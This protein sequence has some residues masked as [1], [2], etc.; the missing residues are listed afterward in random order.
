ML[1]A[2]ARDGFVPRGEK[3]RHRSSRL[4]FSRESEDTTMTMIKSLLSTLLL[5]VTITPSTGSGAFSRGIALNGGASLF[6]IS[7]GGGL[8]GGNKQDNKYV[9]DDVVCTFQS[10]MT[11]S[12]L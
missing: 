6:G 9:I 1:L 5:L 12:C 2:L 3:A 8:F 10:C 7:R 4:T 11:V